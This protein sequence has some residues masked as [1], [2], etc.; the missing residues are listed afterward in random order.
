MGLRSS[1]FVEPVAGADVVNLGSGL[2]QVAAVAGQLVTTYSTDD[3]PMSTQEAYDYFVAGEVGT[4]VANGED[5]ERQSQGS[6]PQ[7]SSSIAIG[8]SS[9]SSSSQA[10]DPTIGVTSTNSS[11]RQGDGGE[12][13]KVEDPGGQSEGGQEQGGQDTGRASGR[14]AEQAPEGCGSTGLSPSGCNLATFVGDGKRRRITG[15]RPD[16]GNHYP[17]GE[18]PPKRSRLAVRMPQ[19]RSLETAEALQ[20]G[21]AGG[22]L[23]FSYAAAGL[24][25]CWKCGAYSRDRA[26]MLRGNCRGKPGE[27]QNYR[28]LRLKNS[29]HPISKAFLG[30]R[31]K[32]LML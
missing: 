4:Q 27:G 1:L 5:Q 22:H 30:E 31:P 21:D 6:T 24:V 23:L 17:M 20:P 19:G 18:P 10:V 29:Q 3:R 28:L 16:L 11:S 26:H 25:F 2:T 13:N 8:N 14:K 7:A 9:G 32:R 12:S 15:K